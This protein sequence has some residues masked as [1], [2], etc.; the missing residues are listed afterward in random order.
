M[1]Y[2]RSCGPLYSR[3]DPATTKI[4]CGEWDTQSTKEPFDYVDRNA[5]RI[6]SHPTFNPKNLKDDFA[7]ILTDGDFELS[8][9]IDTVCL[10]QMDE[11]FNGERCWATGWGKDTFGMLITP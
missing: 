3:L 9:H 2:D 8:K 6:F 10:P 1:H 7:V 5:S 11:E 4:R